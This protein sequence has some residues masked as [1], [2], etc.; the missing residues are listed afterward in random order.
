MKAKW[1]LDYN[2]IK[3]NYYAPISDIFDDLNIEYQITKYNTTSSFNN[4]APFCDEPKFKENDCVVAY[5]S[6]EFIK[7]L[8]YYKKDYIP[9]SYLEDKS[10]YC[11]IYIPK[12]PKKTYLNEQYIMIPFLEFKNNSSRFYKLFNTNNLFIRPD[13]SLKIFT[14][15][16]IS[17]S[18][19]DYEIN[20]LEKLTSVSDST[21]ILI[22]PVLKIKKEYRFVICNRKVIASS[23]YKK[24]DIL[25]VVEG[26][27]NHVSFISQ[28]M[29]ENPWQPDLVY[30]CDVA[31]LE[32]GE[33]KIIELN[34]F[35]S[36]GLYACNL[37]DIIINVSNVAQL[38]HQ[39]DLYLEN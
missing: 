15:T 24:N 1:L 11:S 9:S 35:S 31:E 18:D 20:T 26:A 19:F 39:G 34:S 7:N 16:T 12:L 27:P 29:A 10:L 4:I 38:E 8:N 30:T 36:S 22:S 25:T 32:T 28:S 23:L 13:S 17:I 14:G 37:K 5:G 6:I 33:V 2:I 3:D 21:L